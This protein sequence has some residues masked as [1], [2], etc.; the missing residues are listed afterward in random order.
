[1]G[2]W[3]TVYI[4]GKC[5]SDEVDAL[6]Q[7][8]CVD[9]RKERGRFHCLCY[10]GPS[11]CGLTNWPAERINAVGN[12]AERNYSVEDVAASLRNLIKIAPSLDIKIHCGGDW[13][14]KECVATVQAANGKVA[15]LGPELEILPAIPETQMLGQFFQAIN[16]PKHDAMKG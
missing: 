2:N 5:H 7:A 13:E 1:M 15:I 3:R 14:A 8:V 10:S 12:L 4:V 16:K 11:L 6:R 9:F